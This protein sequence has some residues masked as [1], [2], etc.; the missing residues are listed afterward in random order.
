MPTYVCPNC[1][2]REVIGM[3][4]TVVVGEGEA[5]HTCSNCGAEMKEEN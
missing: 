2:S 5:K 3:E 1:G 4:V